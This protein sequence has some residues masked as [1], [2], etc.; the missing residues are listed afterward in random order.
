MALNTA[1]PPARCRHGRIAACLIDD[2]DKARLGEGEVRIRGR[3]LGEM[4]A[5]HGVDGGLG[6]G[7]ERGVVE[8]MCGEQGLDVRG[9]GGVEMNAGLVDQEP[10]CRFTRA[11]GEERAEESV[12]DA[13]QGSARAG[14]QCLAP[15]GPGALSP[16]A[17]GVARAGRPHRHVPSGQG[18]DAPDPGICEK[19]AR[20]DTK[21]PP[22]R[23]AT[24]G[25]HGPITP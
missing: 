14:G 19:T 24:G 8:G 21:T 1:S 3:E 10:Q 5:R 6:T 25:G 22:G 9:G 23:W 20:A 4:G 12:L 18:Q 7:Q 11:A 13:D 15:M 16:D 2:E 17:D